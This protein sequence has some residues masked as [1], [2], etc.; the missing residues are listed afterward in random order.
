MTD[1][2]RVR[3]WH[4][5]PVAATSSGQHVDPWL[6]TSAFDREIAPIEAVVAKGRFDHHLRRV[7]GDRLAESCH[8]LLL[9]IQ[10]LDHDRPPG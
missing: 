9:E 10:L 4:L 8:Q 7:F 2:Y 5:L 1:H 6:R 3:S